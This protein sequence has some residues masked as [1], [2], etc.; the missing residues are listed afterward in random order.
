MTATP[1]RP[2]GG[3]DWQPASDGAVARLTRKLRGRRDRRR[4]LQAGA[5]VVGGLLALAGG[6]WLVGWATRTPEY[7]HGGLTCSEVARRVDDLRAGRLAPAEV[8]QVRQHV[9]LCP[10]CRPRFEQMGIQLAAAAPACRR[11]ARA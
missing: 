4:L 8:D 5:G 10:V 6:W 9:K 3:D 2:P 1:Q 7:N 11:A